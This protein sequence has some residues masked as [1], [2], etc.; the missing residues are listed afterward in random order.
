MAQ[1]HMK[2]KK[3]LFALLLIE[4]YAYC[5]RIETLWRQNF[6]QHGVAL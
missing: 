5:R 2:K 6:L 1:I 3:S 4:K